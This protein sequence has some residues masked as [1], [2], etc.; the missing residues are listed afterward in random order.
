MGAKILN[1]SINEQQ[2]AFL[3]ENP[4][5]KPSKIIQQAINTLMMSFNKGDLQELIKHERD[6]VKNIMG[7]IQKY[8]DFV[9]SK[10]L[11]EEFLNFK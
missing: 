5:L 3:D 10:G 1:I 11:M 8:I 9:N 7:T 4:T 6:K 2:K